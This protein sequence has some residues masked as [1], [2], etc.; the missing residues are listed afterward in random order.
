LSS[1][2]TYK[3]TFLAAVNL[4]AAGISLFP[5][6]HTFIFPVQFVE[7]L[8]T[9]TSTLSLLPGTSENGGMQHEA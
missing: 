9:L 4:A 7:R 3:V 5:P 2:Q 6:F 1:A 8:F